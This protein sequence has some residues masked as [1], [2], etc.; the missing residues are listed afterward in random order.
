MGASRD[1]WSGAH[2]RRAVWQGATVV[3]ALA[4]AL[5]VAGAPA[6]GESRGA[7]GGP[8]PL[9]IGVTADE[10]GRAAGREKG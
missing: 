1:R 2:R 9:G 7:A 8:S 5:G 10:V 4:V 6:S 3:L